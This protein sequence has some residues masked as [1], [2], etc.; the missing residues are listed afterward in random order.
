MAR[1][2]TRFELSSSVVGP[3]RRLAAGQRA[4]RRTSASA[5]SAYEAMMQAYVRTARELREEREASRAQE[6]LNVAVIESPHDAFVSFDAEGTITGWNARAE[7]L[8]GW[9]A[10]IAIGRPLARTIIPPAMREHHQRG[11][12]RF[13]ATGEDHILNRRLELTALHRDGSELPVDMT[14]TPLRVGDTYRFN[15]FISDATAARRAVRHR[16]VQHGVVLALAQASSVDCALAG[17]LEAVGRGLD[18]ELAAFW[19]ADRAGELLRCEQAWHA[20]AHGL[21]EFAAATRSVEVAAGDGLPG[22]AWGEGARSGSTTCSANARCAGGFRP[23][24][25]GC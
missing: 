21:V 15:A 13:L 22:R 10:P 4:Q 2:A 18:W 8:F 5:D 24:V 6:A 14:I 1:R 9:P 23:R 19:S 7:E 20:D 17:A 3:L 25:L 11:L 12:Q 16:E